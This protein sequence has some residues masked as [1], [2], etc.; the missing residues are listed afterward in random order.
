[1]KK[2]RKERHR[3]QRQTESVLG[4]NEPSHAA[5]EWE[6][7]GEWKLLVARHFLKEGFFES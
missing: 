4:L 3:G 6:E 7:C 5:C 2:K 1:M